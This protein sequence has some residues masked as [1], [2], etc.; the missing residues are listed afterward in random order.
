MPVLEMLQGPHMCSQV[1]SKIQAK[2]RNSPALKTQNPFSEPQTH[3]ITK[4]RR[5][6]HS[7]K[8][9]K[10]EILTWSAAE[11]QNPPQGQISVLFSPQLSHFSLEN[12][13]FCGFLGRILRRRSQRHHRL[14]CLLPPRQQPGRL[15]LHHGKPVPVSALAGTGAA[16]GVPA[17]GFSG[18]G[19]KEFEAVIHVWAQVF[20]ISYQ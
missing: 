8:G 18:A 11:T 16:L 19:L 9:L 7:G 14:C 12:V 6:S 3:I 17:V 2:P 1:C 13:T 15:S 5:K 20:V 4:P 10:R